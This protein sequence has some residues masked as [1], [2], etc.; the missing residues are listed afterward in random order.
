MKLDLNVPFVGLDKKPVVP[1][2]LLS[3]L[4]A[5]LLSVGNTEKSMKT[6]DMSQH[7]YDEGE[8]D[9]DMSDLSFLYDIV[10]KSTL[11]V[12]RVK[13]QILKR[14]IPLLKTPKDV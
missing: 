4:V 1:E 13:D 14:I 6:T 3:R 9:L 5:N 8:V 2:Q 7:F 12:D 10:D 11:I